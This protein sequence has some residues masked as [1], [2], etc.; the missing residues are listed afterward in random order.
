M[1]DESM[2]RWNGTEGYWIDE[3]LPK[4]V[5]IDINTKDECDIQNYA[6]DFVGVMLQ[7]KLVKI[8]EEENKNTEEDNTSIPHV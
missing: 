8:F 4:Y 6:N 3:G 5:A 7:L 2:S 1:V